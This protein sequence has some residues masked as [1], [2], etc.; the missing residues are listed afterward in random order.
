MELDLPPPAFGWPGVVVVAVPLT[1]VDQTL[2][3]LLLVELLVSAGVLI[4]LGA[5]AWWIVRAGLRPLDQ[6]ADHGRGDRSRRP[7]PKGPG[8]NTGTEVGRLG[9][10]LNVMLGEIEESFAA[11]TASE[12]RLRRFLADASHELRTPLTSIRGYAEM[13]DRGARDR[14]ED[15]A[16][17]MRHIRADA[18]R[19]STLVDDLLVLARLDRERPLCTRARRPATGARAG[20]RRHLRTRPRTRSAVGRRGAGRRGWRCKPPASGRRQPS[21]E[22][23]APHAGWNSCRSRPAT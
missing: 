20:S 22:R 12:E 14:P 9:Q 5:V 23:R 16:M 15:L 11:R 18:D 6:M 4:V 17:S 1:D 21:R 8:G 7:D 10:A 3:R 19:M 13:F 2:G